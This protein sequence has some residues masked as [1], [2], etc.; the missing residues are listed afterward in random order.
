MCRLATQATAPALHRRSFFFLTPPPPQ[1]PYTASG[2]A[3][4]GRVT[5]VEMKR[6]AAALAL[7]SRSRSCELGFAERLR[8]RTGTAG[9]KGTEHF[10]ARRDGRAL[11]ESWSRVVN[12]A[13]GALRPR[14]AV[15]CVLFFLFFRVVI[16]FRDATASG[17]HGGGGHKHSAQLARNAVPCLAY[18]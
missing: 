4:N 14:P 10:P 9:E 13:P 15:V 18:S 3:K 2:Q 5:N 1:L 7:V 12:C 11:A 16:F 6:R 8:P 17:Y